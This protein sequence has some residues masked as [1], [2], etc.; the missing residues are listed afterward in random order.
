MNSIL[1]SLPTTVFSIH[2]APRIVRVGK[3]CS[4]IILPFNSAVAGCSRAIWLSRIMVCSILAGTHRVGKLKSRNF[5]DDIV[6]RYS[7]H[8]EEDVVEDLAKHCGLLGQSI[9]RARLTHNQI[10]TVNVSSSINVS[11]KVDQNKA[12]QWHRN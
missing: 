11:K 9:A 10:K 6:S 2:T 7:H 1:P 4:S 5:F 3:K 8:D 12:G